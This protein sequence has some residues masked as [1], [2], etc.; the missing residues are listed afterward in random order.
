[1]PTPQTH[2][3]HRWKPSPIVARE[4]SPTNKLRFQEFLLIA[5]E[6]LVA[7]NAT[8]SLLALIRIVARSAQYDRS[9]STRVTWSH[10]TV[11]WSSTMVRNRICESF[12]RRVALHRQI[13]PAR[14]ADCGRLGAKG[15]RAAD[16]GNRP[17]RPI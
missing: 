13:A 2:R 16:C 10:S 17:A 4:I 8:E 6:L 11:I 1:M 9:S 15:D 7:A 14:R 3:D 12:G 5:D